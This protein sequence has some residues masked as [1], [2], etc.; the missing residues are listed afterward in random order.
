MATRQLQPSANSDDAG[1]SIFTAVQEQ[2][3]LKLQPTKEPVD[4][5]AITLVLVRATK[6]DAWEIPAP[7][8]PPKMMP[9]GADPSFEVAT[10]RPNNSG[11]T[12]MQRFL[13][14]GHRFRTTASS[15]EDLIIQAIRFRPDRL[16]AGVQPATG[17]LTFILRNTTIPFFTV[18]L[19]KHVLDR[20]VV[21]HTGLQGRFDFSVTFMPDE[22]QFNGRPPVVKLDDSVEPAPSF[23]EAMQQQLGLKLTREKIA[24]G[25]MAIDHVEKPSPN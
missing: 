21:D 7:V 4:T 20:S 17:G 10:V 22:T 14:D 23:F 18:F 9:T 12:S 6:P 1:V 25:V 11:A 2:L 19:Q 3:G 8:P 5:L 16:S 13:W 24:V 15:L